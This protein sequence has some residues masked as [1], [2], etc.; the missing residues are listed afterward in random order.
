MN[1]VSAARAL[2]IPAYTGRGTR[3]SHHA[4]STGPTQI[5]SV[6]IGTGLGFGGEWDQAQFWLVLSG[7]GRFVHGE[8]GA[9][10]PA[11]SGHMEYFEPRERRL[12]IAESEA[13]VLIIE[14]NEFRFDGPWAQWQDPDRAIVSHQRVR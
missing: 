11:V 13:R 6:E 1:D 2:G 9:S 3:G 8:S 5:E 14:A 12:F 7:R 4:R 10:I